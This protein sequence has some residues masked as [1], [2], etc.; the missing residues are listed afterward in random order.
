MPGQLFTHHFL[1]DGI[2]ETPE[3]ESSE[4]AALDFQGGL[5]EIFESFRGYQ[6][7]N[8]AVTEQE[9]V[10][11]VLELLGWADYLPQQGAARNEDIPDLLLFPDAASKERAAA[12]SSPQERY[13]DAVVVEESKRFGLP[14]DARDTHDGRR[15]RTPHGQMLRYLSTADIESES[16]VRWGILTSGGVWRLYDYRARPRATGYFEADLG[17]M[18]DSGGEDSLRLVYLLFHRSSFTPQRGPPSAS[19][20]RRWPRAGATRSRLPKTY[21]AWSSRGS[22]PAWSRRWPT[23][24]GRG[25]QRSDRPP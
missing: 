7:P 2:T 25:S 14:L 9:L 24:R 23:A 8:E 21:R 3:W 6:Q 1:T 4:A 18:L 11:P 17:Q 12:R 22:S 19:W 20:K 13:R 5:M 16:R 15:S 10:R